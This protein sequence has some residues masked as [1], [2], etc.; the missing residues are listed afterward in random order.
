MRDLLC[1][2]GLG[3]VISG[4]SSVVFWGLLMPQD[5][6]GRGGKLVVWALFSLPLGLGIAWNLCNG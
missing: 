2:A 4:V 3:S 1:T 6:A 5:Q